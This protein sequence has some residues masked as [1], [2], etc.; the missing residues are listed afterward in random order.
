MPPHDLY[1]NGTVACDHI[2]RKT[3]ETREYYLAISIS[4]RET[5]RTATLIRTSSTDFNMDSA[6]DITVEPV[7]NTSSTNNM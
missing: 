2:F 6:H 4:L 7:V 5:A 1:R 3:S